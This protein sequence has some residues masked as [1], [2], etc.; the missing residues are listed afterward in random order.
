VAAREDRTVIAS[1]DGL[2]DPGRSGRLAD[3]PIAK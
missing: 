2:V 1:P 3:Q